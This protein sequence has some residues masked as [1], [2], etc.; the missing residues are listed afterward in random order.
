MFFLYCRFIALCSVA[1]TLIM[2]APL[3]KTVFTQAIITSNN[4]NTSGLLTFENST[5]GII[6]HYPSDWIIGLNDNNSSNPISKL[7]AVSFLSL[8]SVLND[9]SK[10]P[11]FLTIRT[12]KLPPIY[13]ATNIDT[14][15]AL[16]LE[17][18]KNVHI[19]QSVNTSLAGNP[20]WRVIYSDN[21]NMKE[22][23]AL[24]IWTLSSGRAYHVDFFAEKSKFNRY[25]PIAEKMINSLEIMNSPT[26][27]PFQ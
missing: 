12:I 17:H 14:Y 5:S 13:Y 23:Q 16:N 25:L 2:A 22:V 7:T 18:F 20:A 26:T 24:E 15:T 4:N 9:T 8:K 11:V 27:I 21:S 10:S 3:Q 19:I 6:I 1:L